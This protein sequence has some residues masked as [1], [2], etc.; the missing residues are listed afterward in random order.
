[1]SHIF[2]VTNARLFA[3]YISI[4]RHYTRHT[5]FSIYGLTLLPHM[6]ST[7]IPPT[8]TVGVWR[9]VPPVHHVP[10]QLLME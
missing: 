5:R 3:L 4:V 8:N 7:G 2:F 10:L 9:R 6:R 1:M